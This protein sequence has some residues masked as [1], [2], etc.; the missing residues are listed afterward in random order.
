MGLNTKQKE[1]VEYLDGP[2]LVLA[3]PGTGKT[4]LLSEKVAYILQNTDTSPENI[5][6]LTFTESGASNMRERLKSVIKRDALKVNI[7][8]YHTFGTEILS[9]YRN[10]SETYAR[11]L[12]NAIDEV[13]QFKIIKDIQSHLPVAD[14]LHGDNVKDIVSTISSAKSANLTATDL[15]Q[16]AEQNIADSKVLS[17]TISPLLKNIVP[18]NFD[19]SYTNAYAPIYEILKTYDHIPPILGTIDRNIRPLTTSLTDAIAEATE[20]HKI[21]P[22]SN[23]KDS[24]FEK[25]DHGNYRLKDRI[26]N[27]KLKSLAGV[28]TKYNE[29]LENNNLY[30][31]DDMIMEALRALKTDNGF[32]LT[33]SERYQFI[34]LDEFQDTNPSQFEII[35][36]LTNYEKPMIMAVGDDDQAIYEFQ[37]ASAT[38]LT[39]FRDYYSAH[40][41]TLTENYRSTQEI[42]DFSRQIISQANDRFNNGADKI[43]TAHQ[44]ASE[45]SEITRH[46]FISSDLEYTFVADEISTLIKNGIKQ[47]DIAIIAPKH[48]YIIPILPFL[49]SH[50]E[51]NIAY[52]KRDNL[53]EDEKIRQLIN[54]AKFVVGIATEQP[55]DINI[56]EIMSYP[57]WQFSSFYDVIKISDNARRDKK[58][59]LDYLMNSESPEIRQVANFFADLAAASFNYPLEAMFNYLI[60]ITPLNNYTSPFLSYYSAKDDYQTFELYENLNTLRSK[61]ANHF[62]DKMPKLKD[63]VAMVNDYESADYPI[64]SSSPYRE[65]DDAVQLL[66]A[67]KAK[68][69]EFEYVFIIAADNKAW[70]KGKGNNNMLVLPKNLLQIRHTGTTDSERL[71]LL[72]VAAT[73]AKRHLIIT[74]SI[75]SFDGNSPERLAYL[76]EYINEEKQ[77]ISP[78]LPTQYIE[79]HYEELELDKKTSGLKNWLTPFITPDPNMRAIYTERLTNYRL[80]ASALTSFV[81]VMY[82]GPSTFFKN[83]VLRVPSDTIAEPLVFGDLIHKTFEHI[84]LTK[85][86]NDEAIDF[87]LKELEKT[88]TTPEIAAKMRE[89]GVYSLKISLDNFGEILRAE[90]SL[91][92][93]NL[94]SEHPMLDGIPLTGILDH[95]NIDEKNKT[96]ELY[97]FKT[98]AYHKEGWNSEPTLYKYSLQLGFYK[99]LLNNSS[100]YAKYTVTRG[101]VLFVSPDKEDEVHDKVYEFNDQDEDA[102]KALIHA[103]YTSIKTL[104]FLDNPELLQDPNPTRGIKDIKKFIELLL[105]KYPKI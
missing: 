98:S 59:V 44:P 70:G 21:K 49:K 38:N 63:F 17:E 55:A 48:K 74:N 95:I 62:T 9:A 91:A 15:D 92:E 33:L 43:L 72:Y 102:L 94:F 61:L 65:A 54:I 27:K 46:E 82:A 19:E 99:L 5:L 53:L 4:Q 101:H 67:H 52:E 45:H 84:T 64:Q 25:D 51:I 40:V 31:F 69:L 6:C 36:Q 66:S 79:C 28:M 8:T 100:K 58:S 34:L 30:D 11:H 77:L 29:Y 85:A 32:R 73:R 13:T 68:G 81:D 47:A 12:D 20:A 105:A 10:Y 1:A 16:I 88:N 14:I 97:D 75:R 22:L 78:F 57:F 71:R 37:G 60:G 56:L 7:G 24:F 39:I 93:V 76:A 89:K 96:I 18:R 50:P 2:L 26:A 23:W 87:F 90:N 80:S 35:K 41:V 104:D 83:Y 103:V 42:L 86:S 3:G